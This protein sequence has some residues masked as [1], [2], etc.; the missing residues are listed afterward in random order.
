MSLKKILCICVANFIITFLISQLSHFNRFLHPVMN[1]EGREW[2]LN[3]Q[4]PS[5]S[6]M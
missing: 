6:D 4:K 1:K 3:L 2:L 5:F